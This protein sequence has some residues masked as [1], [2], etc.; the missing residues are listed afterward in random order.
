MSD[1][2]STG[3][4]GGVRTTLRFEGLMLLTAAVL[5][6]AHSGAS[7]ILFFAL[8]LAPDLSFVAYLFG[9]RFGALGYNAVHTTVGPIILALASQLHLATATPL[10]PVALIWFTH[11]GFD[12]ALGYGLKYASGFS[13]THLSFVGKKRAQLA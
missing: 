2:P 12:R 11:I 7:W 6:Y 8:F 5:L 1:H 9:P 4:A 10:L 13:D 3:A